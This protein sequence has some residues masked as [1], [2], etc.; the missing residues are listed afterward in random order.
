[1]SRPATPSKVIGIGRNYRAHAAELGND[2]PTTPLFFLK[3]PSS[4]IGSGEA[5]QLPDASTQVEFEGEIGLV[6]GARLRDASEDEARRAIRAIVAINDV[7][8]RDLQRSDPQWTRA[9]GFDTF[10]PVGAPGAVPAAL[11]ELNVVTRVNG[12]ERQR[13][14][15][16]EM[17]FAI[18]FL[19]AYVS[20]VM[21]LEPG[22]LIATGSPAGVGPLAPGDTVEVEVFDA[23]GARISHV[24]N[25]VVA[26]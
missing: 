10:C 9:K 6:I 5:I 17:V 19:L 12:A 15:V 16:R 7:T 2:V 3:P 14:S 21:T 20:R 26:R 11:D 13:G 24:S 1:M 18:P 8:A 22:D 4:I 23:S 25:P